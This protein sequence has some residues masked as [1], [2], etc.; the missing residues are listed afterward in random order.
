MLV[1]ARC[2][3]CGKVKLCFASTWCD[4]D[5]HGNLRVNGYCPECDDKIQEWLDREL[6]LSRIECER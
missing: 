2:I 6:T 5:K 4:K 1:K 3:E